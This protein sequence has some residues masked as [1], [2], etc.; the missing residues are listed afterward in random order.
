MSL[1]NVLDVSVKNN[2]APFLAPLVF[3]LEFECLQ[4]L[5]DDLE[6]KVIW[7]GSAE[8]T[9]RDQVLEEVMVG[10]VPVG[11]SKFQLEA[12][13]PNPSMIP[14]VSHRAISGT[15][16][17]ASSHLLLIRVALQEDLK[18]VTVMLITCSYRDQEFVRIGYYVNSMMPGDEE[19]I[20]KGESGIEAEPTQMT[21]NILADK[22]RVTKV[23]F[24]LL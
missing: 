10:P 2:P 4:T 15:C 14:V 3:E 9:T 21:R 7:V 19:A 6:W 8:D 24:D 18:G 13:P 23:S 16:V 22:P 12:P 20:E 5:D 1:V 11:V 17:V